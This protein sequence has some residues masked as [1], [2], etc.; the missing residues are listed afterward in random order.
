MARPQ[1]LTLAPGETNVHSVSVTPSLLLFWFK[2]ELTVTNQRISWHSPNTLLAVIPL[3]YSQAAYPLQNTASIAATAR[4]SLWRA[5]FGIFWIIIGLSSLSAGGVGAAFLGLIITF[6]GAGTALNSWRTSLD[7]TNN[8]GGVEQVYVSFRDRKVVEEF[9]REAQTRLFTN[10]EGLRHQESV[11][12]AQAQLYTQQAQLN[13]QM[14]HL[15]MAGP[16]S[17]HAQMQ[18]PNAMAAPQAPGTLPSG[19]STDNNGA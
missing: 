14:Q 7:V 17:A 16:N 13:A 3:G 2:T 5:L 11:S 10:Y 8:G 1:H 6:L 9:A 12:Y 4:F 19:N 18:D 15:A